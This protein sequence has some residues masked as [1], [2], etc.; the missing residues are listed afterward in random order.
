[1]PSRFRPGITT[2]PE[3]EGEE[4]ELGKKRGEEERKGGRK[5]REEGREKGRETGGRGREEGEGGK[6][7]KRREIN[8]L[9]YNPRATLIFYPGLTLTF[10]FNCGGQGRLYISGT[11]R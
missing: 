1:M 8:N 2:S 10:P 5:G 7:G 9:L 6:K 4:R 3:G 11:Y